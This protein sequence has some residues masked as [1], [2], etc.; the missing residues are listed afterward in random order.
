MELH[1]RL[2]VVGRDTCSNHANLG[3]KRPGEESSLDKMHLGRESL[4][5]LSETQFQLCVG[6]LWEEML[7]R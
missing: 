6:K 3:W 1:C 5:V 4:P 2:K 7:V